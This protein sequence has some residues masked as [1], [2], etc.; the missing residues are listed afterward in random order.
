M[1]ATVSEV[2][3]T[4]VGPIRHLAI[5]L[6]EHGGVVVLKGSQGSGKSTAL[7]A[8]SALAGKKP[9]GLS[10]RDGAR[11]GEV[12]CGGAKLT[13]TKS[14]SSRAGEWEVESLGGRFDISRI[15]DPGI[16]D[17]VRADAARI[18]QLLSLTGATTNVNAYLGLIGDEA[19]W[20]ELQ[21]DLEAATDD[22]IEFHK[23][24][25]SACQALARRL[26]K[27][28][29]EATVDVAS[30][31]ERYRGLN[32]NDPPSLDECQRA[33]EE[34]A[35]A[36]AAIQQRIK[37]AR[38]AEQAAIEAREALDTLTEVY[39]GPTVSEANESCTKAFAALKEAEEAL[40]IAHARAEQA[41]REMVAADQARDA[42]KAHERAVAT[43]KSIM[44]RMAGS[45][46]PTPE[47]IEAATKASAESRAAT[48][49]AVRAR[50]GAVLLADALRQNDRADETAAWAEKVRETAKKA[51]AILAETLPLTALRVDDGRIVVKTD[52]SAN[53][54]FAD[55]S[56][57]ERAIAAIHT[58]AAFMAEGDIL[59]IS[60]EIWGGISAE[61][62]R[63]IHEAAQVRGVT[64]FSAEVTDGDL[65]VEVM[66]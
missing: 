3:V 27:Q 15:V 46:A 62:K 41:K 52:R 18:K 60:Q 57:G 19:V 56:H 12:E 22:P 33:Q 58:A 34:A 29:A 55:L 54:L 35:A 65:E 6:P 28:A 1:T 49:N 44:E 14:R 59:V 61:N 21:L 9:D 23:R 24:F 63:A 66:G 20:S 5:P 8:V 4:N 36:L 51:E 47:E 16:A 40:A 31:R 17:P 43:A 37:S 13:I 7:E 48:A 64:V 50:E 25:V 32:L 2:T 26:E 30:L 10:I 53:E 45:A 39:D 42:A 11:R 38:E